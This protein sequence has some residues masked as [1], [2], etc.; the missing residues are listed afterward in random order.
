MIYFS[1]TVRHLSAGIYLVL[2]ISLFMFF[3]VTPAPAAGT[4]IRARLSYHWF[5]QHHA[6]IYAS[7]FA[8]E[9]NKATNGRLKIEVF[10]SGQLFDIRQALSAVS[11]GSVELAGVLDLNFVPVD[12]SFMLGTFG[13]FW[14]DYD[15]QRAFW[16][17]NPVG[18]AKWEGIQ[19]KLG[20]KILCYDPV[21]PSA[22][23]STKPLVGT[24]E[25]LRGRKIRYLTAGEKPG[26]EA[27]GMSVVSV[28]TSEMFSAL[29]QGMIDSFVTNPSALKAYSWWD[30]TKY[31]ELP[32][33]SYVDAFVVANAKWWD[34]LPKDIQQIIL[35]QVSPKISKEATDSVMGYSNAILK[36]FTRDHGG[37]VVTVSKS[38]EKKLIQIYETKVWPV[39]GKE[40]D[41]QVYEAAMKFM[42]HK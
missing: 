37:K 13:Y 32:Y 30:M 34:S 42:G 4:P 33:S 5:P 2:L 9:C 23:F 39:L 15:K 40:M 7:K 19:K 6:A 25:E 21:G 14:K 26:Y 11:S 38:E 3:F 8:E 20:I 35:T 10:H 12:K 36:E 28:S 1:K 24:V 22:M 27:L 16:T 41:P 31:G 17:Q 29:K 18:K